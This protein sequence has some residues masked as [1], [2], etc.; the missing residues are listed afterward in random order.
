MAAWWTTLSEAVATGPARLD[1]RTAVALLVAA[2]YFMENLDATVIT[3]AL[4]AMA[5]DFGEAAAHCRWGLGLPGGPDGLHPG[6]RLGGRRF[7]ARRVFSLAIAV[8]T[9]ASLACRRRACG[10]SR[11]PARCRASAG[12]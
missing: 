4:P 6:Q 9:L 11:W 7:G 1:R 8:F 2:V 12:R 5:R 10:A 3:T